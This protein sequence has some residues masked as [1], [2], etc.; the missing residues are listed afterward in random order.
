MGNLLQRLVLGSMLLSSPVA[1]S[2]AVVWASTSDSV[3]RSTESSSV[4]QPAIIQ[5][6][7]RPAELFDIDEYDGPFNK[8]VGNFS[9]K[10]EIKTVTSPHSHRHAQPCTLDAKEKFHLFLR[11]SF[12]PVNFVGAAWDAGWA[13]Q[14][15]DD[16]SFHEGG[17][18]YGRR[19]RTELTDNVQGDFFN[20]FL[21]PAVFRQDP[22]YY[23]LGS[24]GLRHR[25][26]HAMRH[27][28]V[29]HNDSG[30][31]MFNYA[32]WLGTASSKA[33]SN[34]YH[35]G[36]ERGFGPLAQ[37]TGMGI[38]TDMGLDVL[39]EFWPEIAHKFH[40]PFKTSAQQSLR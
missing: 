9:Q 18:G 22:R 31:L 7:T 28:F 24:G 25:L 12:E 34:L 27:V 8:L 5:P 13:Q 19:Y 39:R 10:L 14:D 2:Q 23:R 36:N 20:T 32:E 17:A 35:P 33:V 37:R 40:L 1:F 3:S 21:Y 38:S 4:I 6:C 15:K 26:L 29:A 30:H 16:P 11:N